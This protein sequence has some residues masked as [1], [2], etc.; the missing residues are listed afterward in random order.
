MGSA[1]CPT[2]RWAKIASRPIA[3][4]PASAQATIAISG[5]APKKATTAPARPTTNAATNHTVG[6][7]PTVVADR[8]GG[9]KPDPWAVGG[10]GPGEPATGPGLVGGA[11]E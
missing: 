7:L 5:L 4:G 10:Q 2:S 3:P 9:S 1:R 11:S 6:G 8:S